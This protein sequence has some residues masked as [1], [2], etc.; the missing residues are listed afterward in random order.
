MENPL[1]LCGRC[2]YQAIRHPLT[3]VLVTPNPGKMTPI[4]WWGSCIIIIAGL[5][6]WLIGAYLKVAGLDEV[7]RALVYIPLGNLF[8][9]SYAFAFN[10]STK[11]GGS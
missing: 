4:P 9:M 5:T 8:G 11:K 2:L 1:H 3:P 6:F 7:G 10:E